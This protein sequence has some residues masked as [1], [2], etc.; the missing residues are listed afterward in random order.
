VARENVLTSEGKERLERELAQ[1]K[2]RGRE[3][4]AERLRQALVLLCCARVAVL[5][6]IR[7][8]QAVTGQQPNATM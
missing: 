3:E 4:I 2:G 5:G 8:A 7:R 1:F 6:R